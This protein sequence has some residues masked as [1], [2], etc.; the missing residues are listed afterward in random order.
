[1]GLDLF[2]G[3][4]YCRAGSYS[5]V[6]ALKV[7][8]IKATIKYLLDHYNENKCRLIGDLRKSYYKD[9]W[10]YERI[11]NFYYFDFPEDLEGL[12]SWVNHSDCDGYLTP[13]ESKNILKTLELIC[14]YFSSSDFF[15]GNRDKTLENFYLYKILKKSVDENK[16][17]EFA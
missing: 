14:P 7:D 8:M 4:T 5:G 17:I 2:V 15:R 6:N 3:E 9:N 11:N 1:M 12:Y 13:E 16:N 10:G